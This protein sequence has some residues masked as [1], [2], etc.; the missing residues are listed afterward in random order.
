[1]LDGATVLAVP[2]RFGQSL[3]V[4]GTTGN[5]TIWKSLDVNGKIWFAGQISKEGGNFNIKK[6][7]GFNFHPKTGETLCNILNGAIKLNPL[8]TANTAT[9]KITAQLGF[10]GDWG[11]GSSSTLINN[12]AQWAGVDAFALLATSFGGSGYDIAAAQNNT[13]ILYHKTGAAPL[14]K[15]VRLDWDF[16]DRLF[17]VHLNTKQDSKTGIAA[18]GKINVP[19]KTVLKITDLSHELLHCR[20]LTDFEA[21]LNAHERLVSKTMGQLCVKA[22]LFPD[23]P[24]TVKSLGAW[25]GDFVLATGGENEKGYFRKK[26]Y[27]TILPFKKMVLL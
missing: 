10:A 24:R 17:F 22:R 2:T 8:F 3:A 9:L 16:K 7:P 23:Y 4:E 18:Y 12:I 21:L 26:G 25:G 1:M 19:K 20:S 13:P 5:K 11:L 15:K 27:S 14:I 6:V